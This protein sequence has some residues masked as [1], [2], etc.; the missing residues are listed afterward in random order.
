MIKP[1]PGCVCEAQPYVISTH[2]K[3]CP[4]FQARTVREAM[5]ALGWVGVQAEEW[6]LDHTYVG[7]TPPTP[8]CREDGGLFVLCGGQ[9]LFK[10][11]AP[12]GVF[13]GSQCVYLVLDQSDGSAWEA[14][15]EAVTPGH[16]NGPKPSDVLRV[17]V[18]A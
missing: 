10:F 5:A 18:S 14:R 13:Q 16:V 6:T 7:L 17:V 9:V 3:T 1:R 15:R 11:P 2:G 8:V 4:H 12:G